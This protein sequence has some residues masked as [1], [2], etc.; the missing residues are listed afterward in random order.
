MHGPPTPSPCR[1]SGASHGWRSSLG[2]DTDGVSDQLVRTGIPPSAGLTPERYELWGA[3]VQVRVRVFLSA[4]ADPQGGSIVCGST[5][6]RETCARQRRDKCG[7][8]A[9]KQG[10]KHCLGQKRAPQG[11][12][13]NQAPACGPN[14]DRRKAQAEGDKEGPGRSRDVDGLPLRLLPTKGTHANPPPGGLSESWGTSV[15]LR[16]SV[17]PCRHVVR[18]CDVCFGYAAEAEPRALQIRQTRCVRCRSVLGLTHSEGIAPKARVQL[19]VFRPS[20][21]LMKFTVAVRIK[22][23][24]QPGQGRCRSLMGFAIRHCEQGPS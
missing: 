6:L 21:E 11:M 14:C 17:R 9:H 13:V 18:V 8:A 20:Q 5:G 19:A 24:K 16:Y 15:E 1:R 10:Q 12:A 2:T 7:V 22:R 4:L 23:V 3:A